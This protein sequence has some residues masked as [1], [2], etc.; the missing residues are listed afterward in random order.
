VRRLRDHSAVTQAAFATG[1][2][3]SVLGV[4]SFDAIGEIDLRRATRL[5]VQD[6]RF[7]P[8]GVLPAKARGLGVTFWNRRV[9]NRLQAS[10]ETLIGSSATVTSACRPHGQVF[11]DGEIWEARCAEGADI[12]ETVSVASRDLLWLVVERLDARGLMHRG[13]TPHGANATGRC[14]TPAMTGA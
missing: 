9:R 5:M 1:E 10:V 12:G 13:V 8:L 4:W 6:G 7:G 14:K 11:V 3:D 2:C